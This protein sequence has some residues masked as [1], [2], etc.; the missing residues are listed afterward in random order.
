MVTFENMKRLSILV[1]F[2]FFSAKGTIAQITTS[3][4]TTVQYVQNVLLGGG[5]TASNITFTGLAKQIAS[6]TSTPSGN[7]GI[8][9]GVYLTSGSNGTISGQLGPSGPSSGFQSIGNNGNGDAYLDGIVGIAG[10][11]DAAVLEFDFIPQADTVRFRYV[12]G[13]EEYNDYVNSVN[14]AFAFVLSG[15]TTALAPTNIAL[16]PGSSTPITINNVNNGNSGGVSAGPCTN[17]SYYRDNINGAINCVYDGLTTVLT[18]KHPVICGEK[19]HIKIAIA[20]ASDD[21]YDSGVFLEAGSFSSIPPVTVYSANSNASFTDSVMVEDC[22]T[23]CVY[24]VRNGSLAQKDSF[25]L[26]VTGNAVLGTDYSMQG[27][28]GFNW[29]AKLIFNVNQDTI[30]FCNLFGIQ[31]NISEQPDTILFTLT[32]YTV[33]GPQTCALSNTIKF[34][35]YVQDYIPM[36]IHQGDTVICNGSSAVLD[37]QLT[38]GLTPYTYSWSPVN[39]ANSSIVTGPVTTTTNYTIS[40]NDLCT[41]QITKQI[42]V[43]PSTLPVL[44][45]TS[46]GKFCLDTLKTLEASVS[47][48]KAPF[49]FDWFAPSGGITPYDTVGLTYYLMQSVT[50]SSGTYSLVVTDQCSKQDTVIFDLTTVDCTVIIPNV[51]TANGDN[52][53]DAFK[54]NG[55]DNFPNSA[56]NVYNRWGKK[57]YSSSDYKNDWKPQ[58]NDG[59]YFYTL[60]VSD[61]RSF[62]GFFQ[63]FQ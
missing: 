39:G 12:F 5:V 21:V 62:N 47:G 14:D 3:T 9:R 7:L 26:Q 58:H 50:P 18:A 43:T 20:D 29:P 37:A 8:N 4:M 13:S 11:N 34:R 56:L 45:I 61:G 57:I 32:T 10:T 35:L 63:I 53:N 55:L 44:S 1:T 24:F 19:Y 49:L 48:G 31:D 27:N 6:Y 36:A 30:K 23:N 33:A 38:G 22:N 17:C 60:E 41:K 15:V 28:P 46:P 2:L 52:V 59:T 25:N 16:I 42:T 54:I 40:I 51:I